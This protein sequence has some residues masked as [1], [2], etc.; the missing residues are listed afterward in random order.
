MRLMEKVA[1]V[2][3]STQ[4]IGRAIALR[5]AREG[6]KV[7]VN[8]RGDKA[9]QDTVNEIA[10]SGGQATFIKADVGREDEVREL[11]AGAVRAYGRIDVL[12]NNAAPSELVR[13]GA[14][15]LVADVKQ[16][17]W[18][19]ILR[20]GLTAV[21]WTCK[22]ALP[23]M[24]AVGGGSIVNISSAGAH[25]STPGLSA[26]AASKG[27]LE[28]FTL[29]LAGEYGGAGIRANSI[30]VGFVVTTDYARERLAD[31]QLGPALRALAMTRP[32]RPE[33]IAN[34]AL[35]LASD[36]SAFITG[37]VLVADGGMI[38]KGHLPRPRVTLPGMAPK[39]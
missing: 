24:R 22:H 30:M 23:H 1:V 31:P 27:G 28:A 14:D 9:G 36:E 4:G 35:F 10:G 15:D 19:D 18:D 32:G 26:Y 2:T 29:T 11:V 16:Q 21:F 13:F 17:N 12:V 6:A 8:G 7:V 37:S 3:G 39:D 34:A 25:Q 20:I 5:F 33:D 38:H